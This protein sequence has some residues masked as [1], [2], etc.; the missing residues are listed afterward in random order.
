MAMNAQ[1]GLFASSQPCITLYDNEID[2]PRLSAATWMV[3]ASDSASGIADTRSP[4]MRN[5]GVAMT[6]AAAKV[7]RHVRGEPFSRCELVKSSP[8]RAAAT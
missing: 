7:N 3:A 2:E 5:T 1:R 6:I 4:L 8:H